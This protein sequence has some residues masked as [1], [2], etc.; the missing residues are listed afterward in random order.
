MFTGSF[1][2][3]FITCVKNRNFVQCVR[4]KTYHLLQRDRE[5]TSSRQEQKSAKLLWLWEGYRQGWQCQCMQHDLSWASRRLSIKF[6]M[7]A[8][9]WRQELRRSREEHGV[10]K[11]LGG[12]KE[13]E[14][15][16]W[17]QRCCRHD[18]LFL[19]DKFDNG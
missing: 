12:K 11:E 1:N 9:H 16:V 13:R 6:H 15:K 8:I 10:N 14:K 18:E 3:A 19:P 4:Y 7:T 2:L 17:G 5:K